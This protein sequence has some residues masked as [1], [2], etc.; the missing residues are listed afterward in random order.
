MKN[1]VKGESLK[2]VEG[3]SV[4]DRVKG[5]SVQI[6]GKG[7]SVKIGFHKFEC[8]LCGYET[9][10]KSSMNK[11]LKTRKHVM[12]VMTIGESVKIGVEKE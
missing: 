5:E 1:G 10:K 3:E 2:T 11:H 7:K 4:V 9:R 12:L 8:K 6:D